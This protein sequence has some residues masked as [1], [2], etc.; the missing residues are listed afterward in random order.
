MTK[1]TTFWLL[2]VS[3]ALSGGCAGGNDLRSQVAR[4]EQQ[5]QQLNA[6]LS[7]VQPAQADTWSQLQTMRQEMSTLRGQIEDFNNATAN[8][9]GLPGLAR[10]VE[11]QHAALLALETQ[12]GMKLNLDAAAAPAAAPGVPGAAAPGSAGGV[13]PGGVTLPPPDSS[14]PVQINPAPGVQAPAAAA[15]GD[16]ATALYDAG[17]AAFNSRNYKGALS[18]FRDFTE[19]YGNHKLIGNGW[20]W[21]GESEFALGNYNEAALDYEQV[22]AKYPNSAKVASAYLKQGMSFARANKKDAARVRLNELIKK[23]PQSPDAARAR[24]VLKEIK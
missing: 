7:G 14:A 15:Q 9:G 8:L 6:Q 5:I 21:R 2:M 24:Q 4:Q 11:Q 1:R 10:R 3:F 12:F 17:I 19:M 16:T 13:M 20:F 23:F 18:S 22:I